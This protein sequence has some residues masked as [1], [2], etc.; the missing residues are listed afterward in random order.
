MDELQ[1]WGEEQLPWLKDDKSSSKTSNPRTPRPD[2]EL[3]DFSV[4]E[5]AAPEDL[6]PELLN[7]VFRFRDPEPVNLD[8]ID[9]A[10]ETA[11]GHPG[12]EL[13]NE[14]FTFR[15]PDQ[16]TYEC[17]VQEAAQLNT[18]PEQRIEGS[19]E[20]ENLRIAYRKYIQTRQSI[21]TIEKQLRIDDLL[22]FVVLQASFWEPQTGVAGA[23]EEL[24]IYRR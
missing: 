15:E 2:L 9:E 7:G 19:P 4:S 5:E 3:G 18:K 14:S 22:W 6:V 1:V 12:R 23:L 21:A 17:R 20:R 11:L 16:L 10:A 8:E 13:L 24:K